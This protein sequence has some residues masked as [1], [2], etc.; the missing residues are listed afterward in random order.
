MTQTWGTVQDVSDYLRKGYWDGTPRQF[1]LDANNNILYY[2]VSGWL[3]DNDGLTQDRANLVHQAFN[4]YG[5][6]LGIDF[7]VTTSTGDDVDFFFSDN[8]Q[9]AYACNA[10]LGNFI[11][12]SFI[13]ISSDWCWGDSSLGGYTFQ[14][15]LHE[16]GH[17]LGLGHPGNYN[18]TADFDTSAIFANDS[19]HMSIMSYFD[20]EQNPHNF[21]EFSFLSTPAVADWNALYNMYGYGNAFAGNTT[22]GF[23]TNISVDDSAVWYNFSDLIT[24]N[25]FT[26]TDGSGY[27]TLDVS[28]FDEVQF[29]N[30]NPTSPD[31]IMPQSSDIGGL[32]GNLTIAPNTIIERAIGG[33]GNDTIIGNNANNTLYGRQGHDWLTGLGGDDIIY[34]GKGN[35]WLTGGP[36][37]DTLYGN[38]GYNT[39]RGDNDG[40]VDTIVIDWCQNSSQA[41]NICSLDTSDQIVMQNFNDRSLSFGYVGNH[42]NVYGDM[43]SGIGIYASNRLQ[44]VY[45]GTNLSYDQVQS[46]T[47]TV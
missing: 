39:F 9:G 4:V 10:G 3:E 28:G 8:D 41:D 27:D 29:I 20:Q 40:D 35:D 44:A 1:D 14:T 25:S 5:N 22:Y 21:V 24:T 17:G 11:D 6:A 34:G 31:D 43:L 7:R 12:Y 30:L 2:N 47:W 16:I 33:Y 45:T 23:N 37:N 38:R 18:I 13:N 46:M 19:W 32:I 15:I 26:I 42:R 36:G